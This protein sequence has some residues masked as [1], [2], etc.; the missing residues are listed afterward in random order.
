MYG[1]ELLAY[2]NQTIEF[3]LP[4]N[5]ELLFVGGI[6]NVFVNLTTSIQNT[7][8]T[9]L[10]CG[11]RVAI[12]S[13]FFTYYPQ[14]KEV[15]LKHII[16]NQTLFSTEL[17]YLTKLVAYFQG[18]TF[19]TLDNTNLHALP[20]LL[21]LDLR[22][23]FFNGIPAGV[24]QKLNK[25]TYLSLDDSSLIHVDAGAFN[26]LSS[27]ER[28]YLSNNGIERISNNVFLGLTSL[29]YLRMTKNPIIP[30]EALI[31]TKSLV[32][33][34]LRFNE[35]EILEFF[36]TDEIIDIYIPIRSFYL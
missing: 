33:I 35:Y 32:H 6:S 17:Q 23:S 12:E 29:T 22:N 2:G 25:L 8:L 24:F 36:S 28:L 14:L 19:H 34:D 20:N 21:Y 3:D 10:N 9:H 15:I 13:D 27:L 5:I 18:P 1:M 16:P 11:Y 4:S 30:V 31:H 26:G 7:G